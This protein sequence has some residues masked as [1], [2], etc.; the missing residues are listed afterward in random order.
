MPAGAPEQKFRF[1]NRYKSAAGR[2]FPG[3]ISEETMSKKNLTPNR[4]FLPTPV[5]LLSCKGRDRRAN[6]ITIAWT[7]VM[8]GDPPIVYASVRPSRH[9]H[10]LLEENGDFVINIPTAEQVQLV[11]L[12]GVVSGRDQD[13]FQLC[14][15]T[16]QVSEKVDAPLIFECPANLECRCRQVLHLGAHDAYIADVLGLLADENAVPQGKKAE[17]Y[18]D[19]LIYATGPRCYHKSA[20]I[21]G[22]HYGFSKKGGPEEE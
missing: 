8:C 5:V 21:P 12:C 13:K 10:S 11:D 15:F 18:F 9:S 6:I 22:A 3:G 1:R 4:F 19:H 14:G 17:S 20:P 2:I 7:G 16:A